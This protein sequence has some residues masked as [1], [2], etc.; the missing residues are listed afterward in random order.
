MKFKYSTVIAAILL[1]SSYSIG[2]SQ[3]RVEMLKTELAQLLKSD[4]DLRELFS[5][6]I[7][8]ERKTE[9]LREYSITD[10]EFKNR[11]WGIT[12]E[13]DSLNL[14][15][16]EKIIREFGYPSKALVG[17][18]LST[19]VWYVL[20]HSDLTAMERYFPTIVRANKT[21]DLPD[22][23]VAMMK[24]R[25]L[26]YQGKEQI[27]GTQGAGRLFKNST[28]GKEEWTN[29]IWPIK[30]WRKVNKLRQS[31]GIK[32]TIE[33]YEKALGLANSKR[34]TLK[35]VKELTEQ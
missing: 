3:D 8:A 4:Q 30:N 34:Y 9:I 23:N 17:S 13:N 6:D 35:E 10:E 33:E 25:M 20:Q 19:A 28:T 12:E 31:V 2:Y 7:N 29:F 18:K 11:G 1:L 16:V 15:K 14:R 21:G 22:A 26:M 5:P 24:D 32:Q 27:Y